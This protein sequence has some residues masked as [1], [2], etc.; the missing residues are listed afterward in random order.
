M[1]R[2]PARRPRISCESRVGRHQARRIDGTP[3]SRGHSEHHR[4]TAGKNAEPPQQGPGV[5]HSRAV[6]TSRCVR[7]IN[8]SDRIGGSWLP[9]GPLSSVVSRSVEDGNGGGNPLHAAHSTGS[10]DA[11]FRGETC[12]RDTP[13]IPTPQVDL[14]H[15]SASPDRYS[16]DRTA[17]TFLFVDIAGFTALRRPTVRG[18]QLSAPS[19]GSGSQ[20]EV[21]GERKAIGDAVSPPSNPRRSA[22]DFDHTCDDDHGSPRRRGP[23]HGH[24]IERDGDYFG[25]SVNLAA[26]VS[27]VAAAARC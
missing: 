23:H 5:R 4:E 27:S 15:G 16:S 14:T 7:S 22:P 17:A 20:R 25:A 9:H 2:C 6:S 19:A 11:R 13:L 26:R 12:L 10:A 18:G 24:A 21:A 1:P 3:A 8:G